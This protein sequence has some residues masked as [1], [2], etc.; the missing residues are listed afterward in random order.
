L[1]AV[2]TLAGA[3]GVAAQGD[4]T[5]RVGSGEPLGAAATRS[6]SRYAALEEALLNAIQQKDRQ[7]AE[8]LFGDGFEVRK[9]ARA[10][11]TPGAEWLAE[12][13]AHAKPTVH[14]HRLAV[15]EW[16][17]LAVVSFLLEGD[18]SPV[19]VVDVWRASSGRLLSRHTAPTSGLAATPTR[20]DGKG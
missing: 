3:A 10:E 8:A 13:W 5:R 4:P 11:A 7:A 17:D 20:P 9:A 18:G 16:D 2:F 15:R 6:V 14:I 12:R 19:F 1:A